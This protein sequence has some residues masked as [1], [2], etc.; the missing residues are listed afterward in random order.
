MKETANQDKMV[1]DYRSSIAARIVEG[2][3]AVLPS[4][5]GLVCELTMD[6]GHVVRGMF[7][8]T[9]LGQ[10]SSKFAQD[11]AQSIAEEK[12]WDLIEYEKILSEQAKEQVKH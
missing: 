6:N 12:L 10:V 11:I 4:G 1:E 9:K 8:T 3:F 7:E 5:L 2:K